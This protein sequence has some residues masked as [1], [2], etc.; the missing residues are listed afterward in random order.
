MCWWL[1]Q[2][3]EIVFREGYLQDLNLCSTA[4][5]INKGEKGTKNCRSIL[6]Y[7]ST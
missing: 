5:Q 4:K 7:D 6:K 2:D 1:E 3:K